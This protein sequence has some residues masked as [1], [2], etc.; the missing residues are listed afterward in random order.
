MELQLEL[1]RRGIPYIVRSG[2]RFFEQAHI[3]DITAYLRLV[4]NPWDELA[5]KRVLK[6]IPR[7]GNATAIK[8][9]DRLVYSDEPLAL[10]KASDGAAL[11]VPR[12]AS[13]GWTEFVKLLKRLTEA[14][15][16]DQPAKQIDLILNSGYQKRLQ[17]TFDNADSRIEDIRQLSLYAARY[18]TTDAFLSELALIN[19]ERYGSGGAIVGEDII[20]GSDEDEHLVLSSIHQAK[21]L[22]WKVVFI[23]WAADGKFPSARSLRDAE[24]GEEERRLFYVGITRA[25]D[26]LYITYPLIVNDFQGYT[27]Q[28]VVQKPSRFISELS[29]E[30]FEIWALEED[31]PALEQGEGQKLIN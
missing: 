29:A 19:T 18:K 1:T 10:V 22:E 9:W 30:M 24:S 16:A 31:L 26:D 21:G 5:W 8:I 11:S 14:E 20:G 6:L 27:R 13:V 17:A 28:M 4:V 25:K 2:V 7:V 3:K 15:M 12:S 23:I